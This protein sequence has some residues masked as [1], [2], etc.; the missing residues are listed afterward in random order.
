MGVL[1]TT[2]FRLTLLELDDYTERGNE[3]KWLADINKVN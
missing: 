3:V 1:R 2:T